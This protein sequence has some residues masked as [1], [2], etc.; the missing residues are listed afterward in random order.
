M[1]RADVRSHAGNMV[2]HRLP[3][4]R[5][6]AGPAIISLSLSLWM[7]FF[8]HPLLYELDHPHLAIDTR[9]C[10][11]FELAVVGEM[12][13]PDHREDPVCALRSACGYNHYQRLS[14][15][16]LRYYLDFITFQVDWITYRIG[17]M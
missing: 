8:S 1:R 6:S 17:L 2:I 13:H 10:G 9:L 15:R 11:Y 5:E 12:P 14:Y 16:V 3:P 7:Q 4:T